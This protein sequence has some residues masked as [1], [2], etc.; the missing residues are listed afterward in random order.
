[1]PYIK[2]NYRDKVDVHLEQVIKFIGGV[3]SDQNA[4]VL[5]Y[6]ITR[7]LHGVCGPYNYYIESPIW[8]YDKINK[9]KGVLACVSDEFND[10]IVRPYEDSKIKENGDVV[11]YQV[12]TS[13]NIKI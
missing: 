10:R 13:E 8:N 9:V 12:W 1:M 6:C 4:G 11:E 7:L 5:N 2:Q 3:G